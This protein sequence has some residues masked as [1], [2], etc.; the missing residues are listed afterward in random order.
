[1]KRIYSSAMPL[2]MRLLLPLVL[3]VLIA[4]GLRTALLWQ[5]EAQRTQHQTRQ[6]TRD[7]IQ[8][9]G[10]RIAELQAL[11]QQDALQAV[12]Q[13]AVTEHAL[14]ARLQWVP[15]RASGP[16]Q[17]AQAQPVAL[18]VPLWVQRLQV[19][20]NMPNALPDVDHEVVLTYRGM[21]IGTLT[22]TLS[23]IPEINR[24]WQSVRLQILTVSGV[25]LV[26]ILAIP[27]VLISS[28]R[29]LTQL[30]H[31]ALLLP[32]Q[33]DLRIHPTGA[34]EVRQLARAFNAMAESLQQAHALASE[35]LVRTTWV[36]NHDALTS[37]P[38]RTLLADR[39]QQALHRCERY[40]ET[41]ALCFIDLD[42]FKPIN[43]QHGH[44]VGDEVLMT[45]AKRMLSELRETDTL[46]RIGGDEFVL[47]LTCLADAGE[48]LTIVERVLTVLRQPIEVHGL[49]LSISGSAGLTLQGPMDVDGG[50]VMADADMLLRQADQVMYQ[51]KQAG[52]DQVKVWESTAGSALVTQQQWAQR[53]KL[54]IHQSELRLYYQPKVHLLRGEV[55]GLEALVRWQ[56]PERGLL[57]PFDFLPQVEHTAAIVDMGQWVMNE[58]LRQIAE[59]QQRG[60]G[61]PVSIN[62]AARHLVR[63]DF[64]DELSKTLLRYPSVKPDWLTL[65]ILE[66]SA[67]DDLAQVRATVQAAQSLGVHCSLDDFGT[68]YSSLSYLKELPVHEI[69]IDQSFVRHMLDDAGDLALVEGVIT[70]GQVFGRQMI[71]EGMETP[72]HGSVLLR[73]GCQLAQGW[74]IAKPMSADLV[75]E[76]VAQYRPDVLWQQWGSVPWPMSDFPLLVA[77]YDHE[78]WVRQ[79]LQTLDGAPL[80]LDADELR[81]HTHCRFGVWYHGQGQAQ[82]GDLEAF[83]AINPVHQEVH[84]LGQEILRLRDAGHLAD[85]HA[86]AEQLVFCKKQMLSHIEDLHQEVLARHHA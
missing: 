64:M 27:L 79:V 69:K 52:R 41:L 23:P 47:I 39:L 51:A 83:R 54:A 33:P 20:D 46:A 53:L 86:V 21:N 43:D 63:Q 5:E 38:N 73:L 22:L 32:E 19:M 60:I 80:H 66:T 3:L 57:M 4:G 7:F 40:Q 72:E 17:Q 55:V 59:W 84:S 49:S 12:L 16:K 78:A 85:A 28:L 37:L 10:P 29:G 14:L 15:S 6:F 50:A 56:H 34:R 70:L 77:K 62:I 68:G 35:Q 44:N 11:G 24:I 8:L 48:A 26:L 42:R 30:S 36:A 74:A 18:T 1:M 82:Y 71:A 9:Y 61:W 13:R 58:A 45:A 67:L 2:L 76:W 75:P 25:L 65:E 81:R 31:A